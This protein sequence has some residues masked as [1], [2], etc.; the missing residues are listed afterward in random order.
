MALYP[1]GHFYKK[2]VDRHQL[3]PSRLL[4]FV[5]YFNDWIPGDGGELILYI[6][7]KEVKIPPVKNS[8]IVFLSELEHQVLPAIQERRSLTAWLRDDVI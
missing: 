4:T 2:H 3:L 1:S 5:L 6:N 8:A 7:E